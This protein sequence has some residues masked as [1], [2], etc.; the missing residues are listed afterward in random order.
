MASAAL[1][2]T[3]V[4]GYL[5]SGMRYCGSSGRFCGQAKRNNAC[6][7]PSAFLSEIAQRAP[8]GEIALE[9]I[10]AEIHQMRREKRSRRG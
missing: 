3:Q 2:G 4:R 7:T 5:G 9:E 6:L 8:D 1:L 10:A